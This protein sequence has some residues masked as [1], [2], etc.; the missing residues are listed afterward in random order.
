MKNKTKINQ[1]DFW[2]GQNFHLNT[3][4]EKKNTLGTEVNILVVMLLRNE[5]QKTTTSTTNKRVNVEGKKNKNHNLF[6]LPRYPPKLNSEYYWQ[7]SDRIQCEC[8]FLYVF[9]IL[10]TDCS[11]FIVRTWCSECVHTLDLGLSSHETWDVRRERTWES[12]VIR[13]SHTNSEILVPVPQSIK[14]KIPNIKKN[15]HKLMI[16]S[17]AF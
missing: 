16:M 7:G 14:T 8:W 17:K 2:H 11:I 6:L 12:Q 1:N 10:R 3:D 5:W 15:N 13:A 4:S 9:T